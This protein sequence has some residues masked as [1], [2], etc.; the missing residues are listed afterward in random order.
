[1]SLS[2]RGDDTRLSLRRQWEAT[3]EVNPDAR[4]KKW[5]LWKWKSGVWETESKR[6]CKIILK[7]NFVLKLIWDGTGNSR[8][9]R[10]W[11]L[12]QSC[13][14]RVPYFLSLFFFWSSQIRPIAYRT[15][16]V[17]RWGRVL[18]TPNGLCVC[19]YHIDTAI[20]NCL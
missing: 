1:V 17:V 11:S 14:Y 19:V 6:V 2:W 7:K 20:P 13:L 10:T 4:N 16:Q 12:F 5:V 8:L 15:K 3:C 9:T 18:C